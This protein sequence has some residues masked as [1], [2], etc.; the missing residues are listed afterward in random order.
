MKL[1]IAFLTLSSFAIDACEFEN[2]QIY[3]VR[4]NSENIEISNS[5]V[6]FPGYLFEKLGVGEFKYEECRDA[7]RE[8]VMK[9]PNGTHFN[10]V[11]TNRD[12]C[13]GG[14]SFGFIVEA[15]TLLPIAVIHDSDISCI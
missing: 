7:I 6:A 9:R 8:V 10:M 5:Y 1:L 11:Y 15:E 13:D 12:Y 14:N 2:G 3:Q 4:T